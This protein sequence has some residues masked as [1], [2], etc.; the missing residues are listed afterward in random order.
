MTRRDMKIHERCP[1]CGGTDLSF[2][3]KTR[4]SVR[5][6]EFSINRCNTCS[7]RFI[8]DPPFPQDIACYYAG[9]PG[10]RMRESGSKLHQA[11]Q[12]ILL[13]RELKPLLARLTQGALVVDYGTGDGR[14]AEFLHEKGYRILSLDMYPEAEW[15]HKKIVYRQRDLNGTSIRKD[16]LLLT[17]P[18]QGK[19]PAAIVVRHVLEHLFEPRKVLAAFR[20]SGIKH[21][22]LTVPNY[23]SP[24]RRF[25]GEYWYYLDPPRHLTHFSRESLAYLANSCGYKIIEM[26]TYGVDEIVTSLHRYILLKQKNGANL[27]SGMAGAVLRV[28]DPKSALAAISSSLSSITGNC[29]IWTLLEQISN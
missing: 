26:K 14:V 23:E 10:T 28:S 13:E 16:D 1:V 20:E 6:D 3:T 18:G 9:A 11:L 29:V 19:E 25:F 12:N 15:V 2:E 24:F 22:L 8:V 21:V 5:H 7:L 17:A 27:D 4:E